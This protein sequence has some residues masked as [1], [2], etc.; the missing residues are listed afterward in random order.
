MIDISLVKALTETWG[1]PGYE[2]RIREVIR[3]YVQDLADEIHVDPSGALVCRMGSGGPKV[4][5]AA[6]MDE[7]GFFIHH[8]DKD[9][10]GRFSLNGTLF[11]LTLT[12]GRVL[13]ENGTVGV[14]GVDNM[15]FPPK[16]PT[17]QDF[18][19]DFDTG[20]GAVNV[21]TG[22]VG[23]MQR[24]MIVRGNRLTAKSMD[25]RIGCVVLIETMRRLKNQGQPLPNEL[26]FT[27]TT[28]EEVGIRGARAAAFSV[29]PDY[30]IAIDVTSTGDV[31]KNEKLDV[32][33]GAGAA[34]KV[35]DAGHIVPPGIKNL[36]IQRA[37]EANIPYQLEILDLGTTDASAIQATRAG[38]PSG[39]ISIP[40]RFV[41]TTSETVDLNDL[42]ACVALLTAVTGKP[43]EV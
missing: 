42:E 33:L 7:I 8:I 19:I 11:P 1:P 38:I 18:Y 35:R 20:D 29:D 10:F 5:I 27:F 31:P 13:F 36:M 4:M 32:K 6:H 40:C 41:H 25:D 30:G 12:G 22:D 23:A 17:T 9:G 26:Y 15:Y 14:V 34:I 39:A 16:V 43:F 3:G 37:T 2:H 28:Q 24:E 21:Q